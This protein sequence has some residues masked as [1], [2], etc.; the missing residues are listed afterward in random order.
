MKLTLIFTIIFLAG[1]SFCR[2]EM[3]KYD[4]HGVILGPD[5]RDCVC[6]GGWYIVIDTTEYEFDALPET[7]AID[8]INENFPLAVKL[9]WQLNARPACPY[10]RIDILRI[11]RE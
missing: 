7:S 2:K 1:M 11:A 10:K 5:F 6:C 4:S 8:L 9:D 3:D